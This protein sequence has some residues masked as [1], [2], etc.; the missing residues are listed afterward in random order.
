MLRLGLGEDYFETY[1]ENSDL[2][3][4][5]SL[6]IKE[7]IDNTGKVFL[8]TRPRRFGKTLNMT[9][10]KAFFGIK[11]EEEKSKYKKY[12]EDL[13]IWQAGEDYLEEFGKYP[14]VFMSLKGGNAR[15]WDDC[16]EWFKTKLANVFK[17]HKYLIDILE[18]EDKI[19]FNDIL[20]ER[21]SLSQLKQ[22]LANLSK[23][24]HKYHGQMVYLL[25]DEYDSPINDGF[26]NGFDIEVIDFVRS[27]FDNVMK[28]NPF[29]KKAVLTG[30][31]KIAGKSLFSTLNNFTSYNVLDNRF[32]DCFGFTEDE[33]E[34]AITKCNVE[35]T[36]QEIRNWYNG[37]KFG[38]TTPI[39]NPWSI[40]NVCSNPDNFLTSYW[41]FT[42]SENALGFVLNN[43][44]VS[45]KEK[46]YQLL[47]GEELELSIHDD[48]TYQTLNESL[49][50]VWTFLLY[51]GY[52]TADRVKRDKAMYRLPN[53][54][55][56]EALTQTM[57]RWLTV[58]MESTNEVDDMISSMLYGEKEDFFDKLSK[59]VFNAFS[60]FDV[61]QFEPE[62]VYHAFL[63]GLMSHVQDEYYFSSNPEAGEGRADVLIMPKSGSLKYNAVVL[64]F[65]KARKEEELQK[66]A[67]LAI[68]QIKKKKY[69]EEAKKRGATKIFIYGV[70]FC[71]RE[72]KMIMEELSFS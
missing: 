64:E 53:F 46:L 56:K 67:E 43:M 31:T 37:Y 48:V 36:M 16:Y 3:I 18:E 14:V 24:F 4:D 47:Q 23:W 39:Y 41:T 45:S 72:I 28:T 61:G 25:I 71:G 10:L 70:G 17:E 57:K 30:I 32:S 12:F 21:A 69:I 51:S 52:L 7:V 11:S 66:K 42:S 50:C 63:L 68:E 59:F 22:S 60:Y 9:M 49:D 20:F 5:K 58:P 44:P 65:K 35:H 38:K 40:M 33:V 8:I 27:L 54:E 13:K 29:I 19:I 55:V 6:L 26:N 62:K 1:R 34:K 2:Y 15:N